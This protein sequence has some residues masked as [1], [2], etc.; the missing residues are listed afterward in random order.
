MEGDVITMQEIFRFERT[1]VDE[2]GTVRGRFLATGVRP[3]C[4]DKLEAAGLKLT[5]E[6]F[7]GMSEV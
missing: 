3:S 7:E 6:I 2:G 1:G 5:Q 4:A